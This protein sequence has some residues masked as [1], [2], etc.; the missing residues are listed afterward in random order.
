LAS[1]DTPVQG[2][3]APAAWDTS[4][5]H[6]RICEELRGR[7]MSG[8]LP[9]GTRIPE[10]R[11]AGELNV[12][13]GTMREALRQLQRERLISWEPRRSP[14]V[15]RM[16]TPEIED[17][18]EVRELL[19]GGAAQVLAALRPRDR[20]RA[21]AELQA[22]FEDLRKAAKESVTARIY[23]ELHFHQS[24]CALAGNQLLLQLWQELRPV[25]QLMLHCVPEP[26]LQGLS[27]ED[28]LELIEAIE[29]G[30]PSEAASVVA[31]HF[32]G[33]ATLLSTYVS[34]PARSRGSVPH[35]RRATTAP[36]NPARRQL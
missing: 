2:P 21:V 6:Q 9:P 20:R 32:S 13:R 31:G 15:R 16:T 35:G 22:A 19:E 3:G 28:H 24:V 5:L 12:S 23:A 1:V 33:G 18:Y 8:L 30:D 27:V 34:G 29:R 17:I 4:T 7:M 36:A 25:I 11:L 14:H 10:A 26:V